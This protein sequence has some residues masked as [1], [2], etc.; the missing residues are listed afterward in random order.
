MKN[1]I[2]N[3]GKIK[4]KIDIGPRGCLDS[5]VLNQEIGSKNKIDIN[6]KIK[7]TQTQIIIHDSTNIECFQGAFSKDWNT[8]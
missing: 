8:A 1:H 5:K 4:L 6:V 7:A 2:R 3:T